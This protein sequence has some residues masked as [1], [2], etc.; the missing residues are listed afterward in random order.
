MLIQWPG[1]GG[2]EAHNDKCLPTY[3]AWARKIHNF[4]IGAIPI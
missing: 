2:S 1:Q 4:L 3:L